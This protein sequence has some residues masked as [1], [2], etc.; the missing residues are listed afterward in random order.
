MNLNFGVNNVNLTFEE[1]LENKINR[2][3]ICLGSRCEYEECLKDSLETIDKCEKHDI[4][5]SVHL[6]LYIFDWYTYDYLSAFFINKDEM[7]REKSFRLLEENLKKL[8]FKKAEYFVLHFPGINH[9]DKDFDDFDE[10]L[11]L[12]LSRVN[13]LA[14][15]YN[16]KIL[17]EYF[18]SNILFN[19][20]NEWIEKINK[21][22]NLGILVD[23]GHLYFASKIV[24]FQFEEAF[25]VLKKEVF[26]F[27]FWTTRGKEYYMNNE[28]YKKYHHIIPNFE[29]YKK[30]GWAFDSK[31]IFKQMINEDKP[32]IIEA[33]NYYKGQEYF[34]KSLKSLK[35]YLY[36][37]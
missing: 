12:S 36:K 3:E 32:T 21:Y 29:Q 35:S 27:H 37:D 5:Y 31:D 17:L 4:K 18:G 7:L 14:I 2:V 19:D 9:E 22:S 11:K 34:I 30:D 8:E 28:Y 24:G 16:T 13:E 25:N 23:T 10:I 20:Y 15:R 1:I 26:A 33:S 6:P